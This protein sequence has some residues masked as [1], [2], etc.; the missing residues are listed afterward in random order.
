MGLTDILRELPQEVL[1]DDYWGDLIHNVGPFIITDKGIYTDFFGPEIF[2]SY[3]FT[4]EKPYKIVRRIVF[5]TDMDKGPKYNEETGERSTRHLCTTICNLFDEDG[6]INEEITLFNMDKFYRYEDEFYKT[7][8]YVRHY[9][10]TK[11]LK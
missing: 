11:G 10:K 4:Y 2:L 6:D 9:L 8:N 7:I 5:V 1:E 3:E